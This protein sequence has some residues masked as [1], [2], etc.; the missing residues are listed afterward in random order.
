MR[1]MWCCASA[2][3]ASPTRCRYCA[4]LSQLTIGRDPQGLRPRTEVPMMTGRG[5]AHIKGNPVL[6]NTLSKGD[7]TNQMKQRCYIMDGR[8]DAR[9]EDSRPSAPRSTQLDLIPCAGTPPP[10]L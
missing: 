6:Q 4:P 2:H 5:S 3:C 8:M 1:L 10:P 9:T 7:P